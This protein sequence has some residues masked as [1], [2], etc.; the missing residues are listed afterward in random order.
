M[1]DARGK[2][3]VRIRII[4]QKGKRKYNL[5]VGDEWIVDGLVSDGICLGTWHHIYPNL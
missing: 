3:K 4:S 5:K 1:L 2:K